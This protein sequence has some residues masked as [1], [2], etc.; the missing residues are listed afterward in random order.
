MKMSM[1]KDID[2][3]PSNTD[4]LLNRKKIYTITRPS[5]YPRKLIFQDH[6]FVFSNKRAHDCKY[7]CKYGSNNHKG[8]S[9]CKATISVPYPLMEI[10]FNKVP[11]TVLDS[12]HTCLDIGEI[13]IKFIK[14]AEVRVMVKEFYISTIP[15]P[16]RSQ[17]ISLVLNRIKEEMP[18][19]QE[20]QTVSLPLI[21]NCYTN[22]KKMLKLLIMI[23]KRC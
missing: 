6:L 19:G 7:F 16:T 14:D 5:G 1:P 2:D 9:I 17:L 21:H 11:V 13:G 4:S 20:V 23:S 10:D 3:K 18:E 15:R 8:K 22:F 12:H